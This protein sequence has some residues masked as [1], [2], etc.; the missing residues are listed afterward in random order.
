LDGLVHSARMSKLIIGLVGQAG[1]GK[2]TMADL[3]Q[4]EYGA[5]YFRFSAMIGSILDR[6]A[7]EKTREKFTTMSE[8]LR[9]TFG[10]DVFSYAIAKD[11]LSAPQD[12]VIIDGI[13]RMEDIVAL[14]PL[15]LFKLVA[16]DADSKLRYERMKAR[17]EKA[18]E[19]NFTWEQFLA[20]EQLPTEVT[21]PFVMKR[22]SKTIMNDGTR[23]DLETTVHE[24]MSEFGY[25]RSKKS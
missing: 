5:G 24:L 14:E 2:G 3:L 8:M 19:K 25:T 23:D 7:L 11:A 6:L 1:C 18:S 9:K 22:A 20:E 21:I 16:I 12:I 15:P 13:R 10:E 17:G 4:H